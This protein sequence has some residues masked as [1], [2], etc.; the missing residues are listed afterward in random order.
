MVLCLTT[1]FDTFS[2]RPAVW[3]ASS[4]FLVL[5]RVHRSI[6]RALLCRQKHK[7]GCSSA[8]ARRRTR[9]VSLWRPFLFVPSSAYFGVFRCFIRLVV[10]LASEPPVFSPLAVFPLAGV[11]RVSAETVAF[12]LPFCGARR[13]LSRQDVSTDIKRLF[14]EAVLHCM[15]LWCRTWPYRWYAATAIF[16]APEFA[17]GTVLLSPDFPFSVLGFSG[18]VSFHPF[19]K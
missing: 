12:R 9:P 6:W 11:E 3:S 1:R 7:F 2:P 18:A 13:C 17:A 5:A 15:C 16:S 8:V 10:L 14:F 19:L 4:A